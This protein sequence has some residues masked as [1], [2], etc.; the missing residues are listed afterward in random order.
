MGYN[1]GKIWKKIL[2]YS[3]M[4]IVC[5]ML[6]VGMPLNLLHSHFR[7]LSLIAGLKNRLEYGMSC[8]MD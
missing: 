3:W 7:R 1:K 2:Q 5:V 4:S 8:G 6:C